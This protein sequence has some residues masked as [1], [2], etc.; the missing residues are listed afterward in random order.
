[1]LAA[2]QQKGSPLT[3]AEVESV[4]D[5]ATCVLLPEAQ[6]LRVRDARSYD[7]IDPEQAWEAWQVVRLTL[8]NTDS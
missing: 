8:I 2:E 7:D 1:L 3:R 6:A 5:C 4:R